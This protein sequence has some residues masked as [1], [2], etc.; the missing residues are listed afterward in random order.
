[1]EVII[2]TLTFQANQL[3]KFIE[4][5]AEQSLRCIAFAYRNLDL[6]DVPSEEQRINWQLPDDDLTLIGIAGMKVYVQ[7]LQMVNYVADSSSSTPFVLKYD[8]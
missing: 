4:D 3:K 2:S 6:E 7:Y 8:I 5:M 1:L